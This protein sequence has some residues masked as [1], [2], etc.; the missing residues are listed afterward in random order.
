MARGSVE[1]SAVLLNANRSLKGEKDAASWLHALYHHKVLDL[2][3]Q[4]GD[5]ASADLAQ[6]AGTAALMNLFRP[7]TA[8]ARKFR[9]VSTVRL[10]AM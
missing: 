9:S 6:R 2:Y 8:S 5:A 7:G 3:G 10:L 4:Q 1:L